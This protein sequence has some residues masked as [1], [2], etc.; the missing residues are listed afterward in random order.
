MLRRRWC[1]A[2]LVLVTVAGRSME[3][4]YRSGDRVLAVRCPGQRV[5]RGQVVVVTAPGA[6]GGWPADAP[7]ATL[8]R[9][10]WLIKRAVAV[11]GDPVPRSVAP[12]VGPGI[13]AVPAGALVVIGDGP[14]SGD[15]RQW[16]FVPVHQ[17]LGVVL[18]TVRRPG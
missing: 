12:M 17:V 2:R 11:A 1:G 9:G 15:S 6:A 18:L 8:S 14:R 4:T 10:D 13:R 5:R 7:P 3:P 16:G